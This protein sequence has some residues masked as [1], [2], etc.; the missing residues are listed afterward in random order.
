[1]IYTT[2]FLGLYLSHLN[3]PNTVYKKE[4]MDN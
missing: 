2:F 3:I 1:M 4:T